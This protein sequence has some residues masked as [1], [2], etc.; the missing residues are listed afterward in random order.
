MNFFQDDGDD[1][2]K[3][4]SH[5]S[6]LSPQPSPPSPQEGGW[7][8][9]RVGLSFLKAAAAVPFSHEP[10]RESRLGL[11]TW[12]RGAISPQMTFGSVWRPF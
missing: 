12:E 11:R 6:G 4:L 1:K 8:W 10:V 2:S 5:Y 9:P 3:S 7:G